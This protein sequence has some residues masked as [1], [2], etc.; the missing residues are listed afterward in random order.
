MYKYI[1]SI[2]GI[3]Y[4]KFIYPLLVL[5]YFWPN[6]ATKVSNGM[7][8]KLYFILL[9]YLTTEPLGNTYILSVYVYSVHV[10]IFLA[11]L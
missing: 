1:Y 9:Y 6:T 11:T 3:Y 10:F 8:N 5:F 2:V 7:H 4:E